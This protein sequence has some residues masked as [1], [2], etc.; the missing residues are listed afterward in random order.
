MLEKI[1]LQYRGSEVTALKAFE[2]YDVE[3]DFIDELLHNDEAKKIPHLVIG[4]WN[5]CYEAGASEKIIAD[6]IKHKAEFA[7]LESLFIGD[8]E[9]E[10]C[11]L[12]WIVQTEYAPLLE[13]FPNLKSLTIKGS[14]QLSF[15]K[16]AHA[17]LTH[18]EIISGGLPS[19][20]IDKIADANLPSLESLRLY[21]GV[22]DYG[23]D[24]NIN[25]ITPLL[26]AGLFPKLTHLGLLNSEIQDEIVAELIKSDILKQLS[27]L[28]LSMGIFSDK[29]G[30]V[31]LDNFEKLRHLEK[32]TIA[33]HFMSNEM[34]EQLQAS[35]LNIEISD[36]QEGEYDADEDY[37]YRYPMYTE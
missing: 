3:S 8:I 27:T 35:G 10:E 15:E 31:L 29:S 5:E 33:Y 7:Y 23:F 21:F 37:D 18:F 30:T 14:Q 25:T 16:I 19:S 24:G 1:T 26:R 32:I 17:N 9:G 4:H 22:D 36:Q 20:V 34:V 12:S 11:E 13:N 2:E 28:D 6:L